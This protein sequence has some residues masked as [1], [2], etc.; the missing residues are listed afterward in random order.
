MSFL[1]FGQEL[2]DHTSAFKQRSK[3]FR[4]GVA[5]PDTPQKL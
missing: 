5:T 4:E 3:R 1:T 2:E